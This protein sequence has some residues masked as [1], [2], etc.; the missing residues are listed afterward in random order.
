VLL[1]Y[2]VL[3][4]EYAVLA[5]TDSLAGLSHSLVKYVKRS[6]LILNVDFG[7]DPES[8]TILRASFSPM[9]N[10][11]TTTRHWVHKTVTGLLTKNVVKKL[12]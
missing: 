8:V 5:E 2:V 1:R 11:T 7:V 6:S 10:N 9:A 12:V 3:M 4:R